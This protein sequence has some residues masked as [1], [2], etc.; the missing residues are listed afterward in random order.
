MAQQAQPQALTRIHGQTQTDKAQVIKDR[1][2]VTENV[3]M[4]TE[5]TEHHNHGLKVQ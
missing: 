5:T 2:A 4:G 3:K 1:V